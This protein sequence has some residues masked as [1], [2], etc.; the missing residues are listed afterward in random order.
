M[1]ASVIPHGGWKLGDVCE[2]LLDGSIVPFRV[3]DRFVEV[4]H[5]RSVMFAVVDLHRHLVDGLFEGV[6]RIGQIRE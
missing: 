4:R 3:L 5:V 1:S 2:N 6:G